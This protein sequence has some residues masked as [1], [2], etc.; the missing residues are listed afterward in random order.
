VNAQKNLLLSYVKWFIVA[1]W[2][3]LL[4]I[5]ENTEP[6]YSV[7]LAFSILAVFYWGVREV[8]LTISARNEKIKNE[9]IHLQSQVNPHFFFNTLNNLYGLIG[10]EPEKAKTMVLQLSE[11]MRYSI[12]DGQKDWVPLEKEIGYIESYIALHGVRYHKKVEIRFHHKVQHTGKKIAPLL[13]IILLE[14]A[15]KH[16]VEKLQRNAYV[17]IDLSRTEDSIV[18]KIVNNY[19]ENERARIIG[20][21]LNNL[22]RRLALIYPKKHTLTLLEENLVYTAQLTLQIR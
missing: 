15:F 2:A 3:L 4:I 5:L 13:F 7:F 11:M 10:H 14:N 16:G 21:G 22:R 19:D 8:R 18:F 1:N 9:L 20:I 6:F 17:H 12:Y